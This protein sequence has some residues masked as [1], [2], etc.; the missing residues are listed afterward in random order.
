MSPFVGCLAEF[1]DFLSDH[2]RC[3]PVIQPLRSRLETSTFVFR[4]ELI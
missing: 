2:L 1:N 3:G 4:K